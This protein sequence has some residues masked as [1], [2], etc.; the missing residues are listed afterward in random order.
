M[1]TVLC[2]FIV[3]VNLHEGMI[4]VLKMLVFLFLFTTFLNNV[5]PINTV[6]ILY[7]MPF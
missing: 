4:V 5:S 6:D 7:I 2:H 1:L 3:Y